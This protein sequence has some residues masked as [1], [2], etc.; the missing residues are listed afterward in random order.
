MRQGIGTEFGPEVGRTYLDLARA[1]EIPGYEPTTFRHATARAAEHLLPDEVSPL[2]GEQLLDILANLID[3]KDPYT[4][5]H[6]RRVAILA[7]AVAGQLGLRD[8]MKSA[9]WAG[10]YLHD[11]GKLKIPLRILTKDT[12]LA[13]E[14]FALVK[15]H[16]SEGAQILETI[17]SLRHLTTAARYHHERWDG[18]GY[19]EGLS[20]DH[21]PTVAQILAVC[22]AYDAMTSRRAY[23]D[24][25]THEEAL[26]E[27]ARSTGLHFGPK[28]AAAFLALPEH[29][30][31]S[32][33]ATRMDQ[34]GAPVARSGGSRSRHAG[35]VRRSVAG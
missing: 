27:V 28:V 5:G 7:V 10:G 34:P 19:P 17:P 6:S 29:I 4:A 9:V 11:L 26:E 23:R 3:A 18:N 21:I 13:R 24:S 8:F 15:R 33:R 16:P 2:S 22:D 20:G 31:E 14:E 12:R 30:F 32:I 25:R 35:R 1:R